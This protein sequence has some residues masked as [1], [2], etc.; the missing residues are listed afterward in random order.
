M[1]CP[2]GGNISEEAISIRKN[3][4]ITL[5]MTAS[6]LKTGSREKVTNVILLTKNSILLASTFHQS[7]NQNY[8]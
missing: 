3:I 2:L 4:G 6:L 5:K 8:L 1:F 7:R